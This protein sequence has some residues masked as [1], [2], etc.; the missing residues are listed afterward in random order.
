MKYK[1]IIRPEA[2]NDLKEAFSW[3]EDN[4]LGL[5]YDFLL[6]V[7]VGLRFIERKPEIHAPEYKGTRKHLIKR[8]PYKIIYLVEKER[9]IVLA[10]IHGKRSPDLIKK[11]IDS[12]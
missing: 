10:V 8:F 11:R 12:V 3:Y 1:V 6:R 7:D 4:R 9:I 2:E 5:G